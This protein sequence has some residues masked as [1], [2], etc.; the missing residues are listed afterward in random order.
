MLYVDEALVV[1]YGGHEDQ[2][3]RRVWGLDRL[4]IRA[5]EKVLASD[6]LEPGDRE[7]ARAVLV[8]KIRI[9]LDGARKRGRLDAVRR[10]EGKLQHWQAGSASGSGRGAESRVRGAG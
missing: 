7:A 3:S 2:L 5:L 8:E 6:D 1:K 9:V 4:R 10:Y